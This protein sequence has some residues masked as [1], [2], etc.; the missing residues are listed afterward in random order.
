MQKACVLGPSTLQFE[1]LQCDLGS[2]YR[3][4]HY[5][6]QCVTESKAEMAADPV[7][8]VKGTYAI[9]QKESDRYQVDHL[10]SASSQNGTICQTDAELMRSI[11]ASFNGL[12]VL[13]HLR[14][15]F[16][17]DNPFPPHLQLIQMYQNVVVVA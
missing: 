11:R 17:V 12:Q 9:G 15:G 6:G 1:L 5:G 4:Q 3:L 13:G 10:F 8:I 2:P 16:P 7:L 14:W